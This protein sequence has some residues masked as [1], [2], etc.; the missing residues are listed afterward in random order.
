MIANPRKT[1]RLQVDLSTLKSVLP[2]LSPYLSENIEVII[3][4]R[5][6]TN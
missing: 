3:I 1:I 5:I 4:K 6:M 2:K